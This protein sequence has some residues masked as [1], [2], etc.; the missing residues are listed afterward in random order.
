MTR[1]L[2]I[3]DEIGVFS[4]TF[5]D[6]RPDTQVDKSSVALQL[7]QFHFQ[8]AVG[9]HRAVFVEGGMREGCCLF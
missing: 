8:T 6:K 4:S 3:H 9:A 1:K 5:A 2:L 7:T